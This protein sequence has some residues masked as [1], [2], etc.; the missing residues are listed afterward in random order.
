MRSRGGRPDGTGP[1]VVSRRRC[2]HAPWTPRMNVVATVAL[3]YALLAIVANAIVIALL[4]LALASGRSSTAQRLARRHPVEPGAERPGRR[5]RRGGAGDGRE[6]VLLRGRPL[7]AVPPVLVPADRDVPAGRDP[8]H[9]RLAS[10]PRRPT[11]RRAARGDRRGHL[12][13]PLRCSSGSRRST[14]ASAPRP[15]RARVVWFRQLGF[16]SLPYLAL[17]AFLLILSLLWLARAPSR[18]TPIEDLDDE[19]A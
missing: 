1:E 17:S 9:R 7:R 8:G 14:R 19:D 3:F 16:V 11:I 10:R 18:Q 15:R 12:D 13:V 2:R 5:V 6:P 4:V